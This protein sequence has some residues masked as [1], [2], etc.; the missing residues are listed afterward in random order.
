[1]SRTRNSSHNNPP[2]KS[3]RGFT[4]IELLVVI[5]IIAVLIA[6]L[7]PAVQQ[8]RE[9]ARRAQ[10][11]NNLKQLGLAIHNYHGTHGSFPA[12]VIWTDVE[13]DGDADTGTDHWSWGT[14]S[15]P[16]LEQANLYERMRPGQLTPPQT[17]LA[18]PG[19]F[20]TALS[21]F[22]CPSD[23]GGVND[24][25]CDNSRELDSLDPQEDDQLIALSNYVGNNDANDLADYTSDAIH[26]GTGVF[27]Y[28][29]VVSIRDIVDGTSNT[30]AIGE[31]DSFENGVVT[32]D[33]GNIYAVNDWDQVDHRDGA[34]AA[35]GVGASV[36]NETVNNGQASEGF[37]SQHTGGAQ[38][39]LCDGSVKFISENI[40]AHSHRLGNPDFPRFHT[41]QR[42]L[43]RRDRLPV[44]SF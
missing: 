26:Q 27:L 44:G 23:D 13:Q 7:L 14:F 8:A 19:I 40:D 22:R 1:M 2:P 36:I 9:A 25:L 4:L 20:K 34:Q 30:I 39:L 11:S 3:P 17:Q 5:A 28:N 38:F 33:A 18:Q 10:C 43:N 32:H 24:P 6:L 29:G 15:L 41:F 35:L 37:S 21:G 12:G 16:F 31:R 42:L